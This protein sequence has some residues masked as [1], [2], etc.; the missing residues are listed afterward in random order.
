MIYTV[1]YSF[2]QTPTKRADCYPLILNSPTCEVE[3]KL[4]AGQEANNYTLTICVSVFDGAYSEAFH[5][6]TRVRVTPRAMKS[7]EFQSNSPF[8]TDIIGA[9]KSGSVVSMA[10]IALPLLSAINQVSKDASGAANDTDPVAAEKRRK[11]RSAAKA[12]V[13]DAAR[14]AI[15]SF[16]P[17]ASETEQL[18]T[19]QLSGE[20]LKGANSVPNEISE[21]S[22]ENTVAAG[23]LISKR[24]VD[25][26]SSEDVT[27]DQIKETSSLVLASS[28]NMLDEIVR[29]QQSTMSNN[30]DSNSGGGG[31]GVDT[32]TL[33]SEERLRRSDVSLRALE[34]FRTTG[35][36]LGNKQVAGET[37]TTIDLG[38]IKMNVE[39]QSTNSIVGKKFGKGSG[40]DSGCSIGTGQSANGSIFVEPSQY[41]PNELKPSQAVVAQVIENGANIFTMAGN[42]SRMSSPVLSV[43]IYNDRQYQFPVK[44]LN[45]DSLVEVWVSNHPDAVAAIKPEVNATRPKSER[46][47][48]T[49]VSVKQFDGLFAQVKHYTAEPIQSEN[50]NSMNESTT[51]RTETTTEAATT[52][53]S[54]T[55]NGPANDE[56]IEYLVFIS[57][58]KA[59]TE[60]N[61]DH[62]CQLPLLETRTCSR[63]TARQAATEYTVGSLDGSGPDAATAAK[64]AAPTTVATDYQVES[65]NCSGTDGSGPCS[66]LGAS[67]TSTDVTGAW[68]LTKCVCNSTGCARTSGEDSSVPESVYEAD[69]WTCFFSPVNLGTNDT[70]KEFFIGIRAVRTL[71]SNRTD[72]NPNRLPSLD[73]KVPETDYVVTNYSAT[74]FTSGCF[75]VDMKTFKL[76]SDGVY[77]SQCSTINST[78]CY[79]SH[80]TSFMS[81]FVVPP[82]QIDPNDSAW[83]KLDSNPIALALVLSIV[84]FYFIIL[85]WVRRKDEK[86][87]ERVGITPLMDNHPADVFRYELTFWTGARRQAGTTANVSFILYGEDDESAPRLVQ[88]PKRP[89]LT[90][91]SVDSFL[92]TTPYYL[93]KLTHLRIWHDNSGSSPKWYLNRLLIQDLQTKEKY[94]F[95]CNRWFAFDEDDGMV[96]RILTVSGREEV[97]KFDVVFWSKAQKNLND[98][99]IWLSVVTRPPRS[100]FTRVQRATACLVLLLSTMMVNLMFYGQ[101]AKVESPQ[102]IEFG[103]VKFTAHSIYLATVSTLIILPVNVL[104]V[105]L[106]KNRRSK[107]PPGVKKMDAQPRQPD[108]DQDDRDDEKPGSA[109]PR[110]AVTPRAVR[111]SDVTEPAPADSRL[112]MRQKSS[113]AGG[114]ASNQNNDD[115]EDDE[116]KDKKPSVMTRLR[117]YIR[118]FWPLPWWTHYVGYCLAVVWIGVCTYLMVEFG[119]VLGEEKTAEWLAAMFVTLF[120][121]IILVQ[122]VKILVL[123]IVYA[124]LVKKIEEDEDEVTRDLVM[125]GAAKMHQRMTMRDLSDPAK[126][127]AF[128]RSRRVPPPPDLET[129]RALREQRIKEQAMNDILGDIMF[130]II[131]L[132]ILT[133]AAYTNQDYR[134]FIQNHLVKGTIT[135]VDADGPNLDSVQRIEDLFTYVGEFAAPRLY[136]NVCY[137]GEVCDMAGPGWSWDPHLFLVRKPQLRQLRIKR[138]GTCKIEKYFKDSIYECR[139]EYS[140]LNDDEASYLPMWQP[141]NSS[142]PE[143]TEWSYTGA[144][145]L[146]GIP[147]SGYLSTY[148]G[149]GYVA[150]LGKSAVEAKQMT[151]YLRNN[152]WIDKHTRAVFF[153]FLIYNP[154]T[155]LFTFSE[156][157]FEAFNGGGF[158]KYP[159]VYTLRLN[160]YV[161]A[162]GAFFMAV[163]ILSLI[164][165]VFFVYRECKE[166][167]KLGCLYFRDV[168][169]VMDFLLLIFSCIEV[170]LFIIKITAQQGVSYFMKKYPERF[171]NFQWLILWAQMNQLFLGLVVFVFT[172]RFLRLLSF[173]R[174]M[175]MLGY[176]LKTAAKPLGY[177]LVVFF[178]MFFAFVQ[179]GYFM[180]NVKVES[181]K[182]L[183]NCI[184]TLGVMTLNKFDF[185]TFVVGGGQLGMVFFFVYMVFVSFVLINFFITIINVSFSQVKQSW[186]ETRNKYD[187]V[188]YVVKSIKSVF[189]INPQKRLNHIDHQFAYM[190]ETSKFEQQVEELDD[191]LFELEFYIRNMGILNGQELQESATAKKRVKGKVF[192]SE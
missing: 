122:P 83:L 189:G 157:L 62:F 103:P 98:G 73:L 36:A 25:L 153:E 26:S 131:F 77:L 129:L 106:F 130:Y 173:N 151:E 181:F 78:L 175:M 54:T 59:P 89:V 74:T 192:L 119:G 5:A 104:V 10:Q 33:S 162:N 27:Y 107:P 187:I 148:A 9:G 113:N 4:P 68:L 51:F 63:S 179:L 24:L 137:N 118:R 64:S 46:M 159:Q 156:I 55:T 28:L 11:E 39:K 102:L 93:G 134:S 56:M 149:G 60:Q 139:P 32:S 110:S 88:D 92:M 72:R 1:G 58:G 31:G 37:P 114:T 121:S 52:L 154:N 128:L 178:I 177:F 161:G 120:Q 109:N 142:Y 140:M 183:I 34:N 125:A 18:Q 29:S 155:N 168:F 71:A 94:F 44:D 160:R 75:Y 79:S 19:L 40:K 84:C 143:Q 96:D 76:S 127:K 16:N 17:N 185:T 81:S 41:D 116:E 124:L 172:I 186:G 2:E 35:L 30:S 69:R 15:E 184:E 163:D 164:F 123:A 70:T 48:I 111:L 65:C 191:K 6:Q 3:A 14:N 147:Y 180:F 91:N 169:N 108:D 97:R 47:L 166:L 7:E 50:D 170:V 152:S 165:I 13:V 146:F 67:A 100:K 174:K 85:I 136:S 112:D 190:A 12:L 45:D 42:G 133:M 61:Y 115:D 80:L 167:H 57:A 171:I 150:S 86:D 158:V 22:K 117:P 8:F 176:V 145:K 99:H 20:M 188:D 138:P 43:G 182:S 82:I 132:I 101:T 87:F 49:K 126:M 90:R 66:K 21:S 53:E 135:G 23:D 105:V 95:I 38:N 141:F 144:I